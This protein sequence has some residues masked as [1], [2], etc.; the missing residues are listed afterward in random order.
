[1]AIV[2]PSN[3]AFMRVVSMHMVVGVLL[4]MRNACADIAADDNDDVGYANDDCVTGDYV[5]VGCVHD[6]ILLGDSDEE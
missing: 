6:A 4:V 2:I 3:R 1:M 5:A